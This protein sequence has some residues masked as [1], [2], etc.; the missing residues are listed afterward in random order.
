LKIIG[1]GYEEEMDDLSTP[2]EHRLQSTKAMFFFEGPILILVTY[3]LSLAFH[4]KFGFWVWFVIAFCILSLIY[5][6]YK[7]FKN[8]VFIKLGTKVT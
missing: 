8:N 7:Y 2:F 4:F 5:D 1:T 3:F 6:W